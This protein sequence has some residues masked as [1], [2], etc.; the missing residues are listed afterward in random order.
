MGVISPYDISGQ[1]RQLK[2]MAKDRRARDEKLIDVLQTQ[3]RDF[4]AQVRREEDLREEHP[5]LQDA[6][7]KYQSILKLV[8]E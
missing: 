1:A 8:S 7:E 2:N 6:W 3:V 4:R 5:A